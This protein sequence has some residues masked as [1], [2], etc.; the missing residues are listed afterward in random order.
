[1]SGDLLT[2]LR[3]IEPTDEELGKVRRRRA[4]EPKKSPRRSGP[5]IVA[6]A[7]LSAGAFAVT[8]AL[9]GATTATNALRAAAAAAGQAAPADFTG[10]RYVEMIDRRQGEWATYD[11]DCMRRHSLPRP[12]TPGATAGDVPRCPVSARASYEEEGRQEI[13]VDSRWR[14]TRRDHGSQI[15]W[16]TGDD[17]LGQAIERDFGR[18][19]STHEYV[20]GEGPFARAPLAD[21]PTDPVDLMTTLS[22]AYDDNRWGEGGTLA[23]DSVEVK[24]FELASFTAHMLAESNATPALRSAAFEMLATTMPDVVDLGAVEDSQGRVGHGIEVHGRVL[25]PQST[26]GTLPARL[27]VVFDPERGEVL[28]WSRWHP[29]GLVERTLVRTAHVRTRPSVP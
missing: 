13:W 24:R 7:V 25:W 17:R 22:A 14:G 6:I 18:K 8:A 10:Y 15:V 2:P 28:F 1:M 3:E 23:T 5:A 11:E 19:P 4:L 16:T 20:Y 26:A 12:A 27:R 29:E 21:L 9:P